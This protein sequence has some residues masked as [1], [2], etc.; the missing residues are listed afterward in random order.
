MSNLVDAAQVASG[1]AALAAVWLSVT[2]ARAARRVP[3]TDA[4]VGA[5]QSILDV[6]TAAAAYRE[7]PFPR[8]EAERHMRQFRAADK[9]LSAVEAALRVRVY[10]R[11]IRFDLHNLV[12]DVLFSA[13]EAPEPVGH[14][15]TVADYPRPLWAD[16]SNDEWERVINSVPVGWML[17]TQICGLPGDPDD[18]EGL[19][20]WYYRVV[21]GGLGRSD[22]DTVTAPDSPPQAQLA[23]LLNAY[24]DTFLLPWIRDATREALIGRL[25]PRGRARL[26]R[27]R[28]QRL[29]HV[30]MP[31]WPRPAV[32][33]VRLFDPTDTRR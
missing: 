16:C 1:L 4:Y 23:F 32:P 11:D 3:M 33:G 27:Q 22:A 9:H 7:E 25:G 8:D 6:V 18:T 29:R 13:R 21:L 30:R 20:R 28:R 10:G 26:W 19:L 24:V 17:A 2:T 14:G 12:V 5:W 15:L 31:W